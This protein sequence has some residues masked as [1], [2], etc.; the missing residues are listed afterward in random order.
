MCDIGLALYSFN[1]SDTFAF[2]QVKYIYFTIIII[3][4]VI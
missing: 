3:F 4:I 1:I 2:I